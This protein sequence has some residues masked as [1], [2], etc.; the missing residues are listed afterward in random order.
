M[1]KCFSNCFGIVSLLS[2]YLVLSLPET[3][4]FDGSV[5]VFDVSR[6]C[7]VRAVETVPSASGFGLE[8]LDNRKY[9]DGFDTRAFHVRYVTHDIEFWVEHLEF[10]NEFLD[11]H[12]VALFVSMCLVLRGFIEEVFILVQVE[13]FLEFVFVP[14]FVIVVA[15]WD[16][17]VLILPVI[18]FWSFIYIGHEFMAGTADCT[19]GESIDEYGILVHINHGYVPFCMWGLYMFVWTI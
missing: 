8:H 18:W 13:F 19:G 11:F 12:F 15:V 17:D 4:S 6:V 16:A 7:I 5:L 10:F 9:V 1:L 3:D 2:L 14:D